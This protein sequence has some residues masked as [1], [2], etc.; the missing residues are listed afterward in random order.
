MTQA[1][2]CTVH[3]IRHGETEWNCTGRW[4]GHLDVPLNAAGREQASR[5]ARRLAEE[6]MQF[7]A[8]YSS[9]LKRAWE[10]AE[11][12]GGALGLSPAASPSLREIDLG[13]WS[14]KTREEIARQ[15]PA[16]WQKLHSEE[17]VPRGGG[18]TFAAFQQ[19]VLGWL[20]RAAEEH[21]GKT[22]C[23]VTH[24]GCIRAVLLH[25]L[26]LTWPER[27]Q[28][29]PIENVSITEVECSGG[30]WTVLRVNDTGS[31]KPSESAE[32][33]PE[34]NEGQLA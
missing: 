12:I 9:D 20:N 26:G 14:G 34:W 21:A 3:L 6:R 10:T 19:R 29:P 8:L 33:H 24:G 25:V 15:F 17:D 4:Q 13:A 30:R 16:E 1:T 28:I 2:A 31:I 22:I 23:V 11:P 32:S 18:E 27:A 5:L 7:D